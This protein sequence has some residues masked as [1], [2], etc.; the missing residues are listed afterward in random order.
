MY[1]SRDGVVGVV[2]G[3]VLCGHDRAT[4]RALLFHALP[5]AMETAVLY[6]SHVE[7]CVAADA[8]A[9]R[10]AYMSMIFRLVFDMQAG[11]AH[12]LARFPPSVLCRLSHRVL[13][14]G[15]GA[16]DKAGVHFSTLLQR[17]EAAVASAAT[18]T[19][20]IPAVHTAAINRCP[21]CRATTNIQ[22]V[23]GQ[24]RSGDEGMTMQCMCGS[25]GATWHAR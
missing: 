22:K 16:R 24:L 21:K 14:A 20:A 5:R 23:A 25:C 7:A 4:A 6:A 2:G 19:A 12:L 11:G 17:A 3:S 1:V 15:N 8:R 13:D 18:A 9:D 10:R